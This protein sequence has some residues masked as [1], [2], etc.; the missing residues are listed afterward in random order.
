VPAVVVD[1]K[2]KTSGTLA[3]TYPRMVEIIDELAKEELAGK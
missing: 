2:Y 3:G 1:G